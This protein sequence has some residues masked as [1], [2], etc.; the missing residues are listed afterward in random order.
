VN[1]PDAVS[2]NTFNADNGMSG[3]NGTTLGNDA[4]GNLTGDGTN[5][6]T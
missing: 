3:L 4:N 1:R 6:Y 2:G 5:T